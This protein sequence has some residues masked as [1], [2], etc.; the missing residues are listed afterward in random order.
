MSG[1]TIPAAKVSQPTQLHTCALPQLN[2]ADFIWEVCVAVGLPR[3][4][5]QLHRL[6]Q[7][8]AAVISSTPVESLVVHLKLVRC[9]C[10]RR[11]SCSLT[12]SMVSASSAPALAAA[13]MSLSTPSTSCSQV[14]S[15]DRAQVT[16][17]WTCLCFPS[18]PAWHCCR[19]QQ[20][21][22]R[23]T[24]CRHFCFCG[25]DHPRPL[26]SISVAALLWDLGNATTLAESP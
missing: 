10:R 3:G 24:V 12:S 21:I 11:A 6:P 26:N 5:R 19:G 25:V 2:S 18:C 16:L 13:T 4:T 15:E 14:L 8:L 17:I 1:S 20:N 23:C 7:L 9:L 22:S